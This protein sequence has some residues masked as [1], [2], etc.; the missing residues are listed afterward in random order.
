MPARKIILLS[1]IPIAIVSL[2]IFL[3]GLNIPFLDQWEVVG[4]LEKQQQGSLAF[5]DLFAQHNEHRPFFPRLIWIVLSEFTRY[6]VNAQ[7]WVNLFIAL[8]TFVFFV[9]RAVRT[10]EQRGVDAPWFLIPVLSLL[11][12]NLGQRE[13]WLQGIQTIMFLGTACVLI[14]FFLLAEGSDWVR[15]WS[16]ILLGGTATFSMANGLLYWPIGLIVLWITTSPGIR[17][18]RLLLW[19]AVSFVC[20]GLFF[21]NWTSS[22]HLNLLYVLTHP[23]EWLMW[24]LDFLGSPLMTLWYVAWIFGVLSIVLYSLIIRHLLITRDWKPVVPYFAIAFF[25]LLT[26]CSI[27]LGRMEMGMRQAVVPRYLT[28][29]VWY[30]ASLFTLLP[31]LEMKV[32]HRRILYS[33]LTAS[34]IFLTIGGGWRGHVS[35]YQRILPAYQAVQSGQPLSDEALAQ[36]SSNPVTARSRLDFLCENKLSV[37]AETP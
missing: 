31:L 35:L 7:L 25:I 27:S 2:Y 30:W 1:S 13:S 28:M 32:P 22:G 33:L 6:N 5:S 23:V 24:I 29:S 37:C 3:F 34:L 18:L 26:G 16:A 36:I 9:S 20:I 10:M 15:F 4:L 21:A 19:T 12:F 17:S 14:G 8:G 11:V